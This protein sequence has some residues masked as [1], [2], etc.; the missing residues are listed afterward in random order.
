MAGI[1]VASHAATSLRVESTP[2]EPIGGGIVREYNSAN[3]TFETQCSAES[4]NVTVDRT[5]HRW[6]LGFVAPR[7]LELGVDVYEDATG[8]GRPL[9]MRPE[10]FIQG[11]GAYCSADMYGR[12]VIRE[13]VCSGGVVQSLAVDAEQHCGSPDAPALKTYLRINSTIAPI[14]MQPTASAGRD[15]SVTEGALVTLDGSRSFAPGTIASVSWQQTS[16]PSVTLSDPASLRPSFTAPPVGAGGTTLEFEISVTGSNALVDSNR[17]QV[18]VRDE[19]DPQTLV[20]LVSSPGD[21]IGSGVTRGFNSDTAFFTAT[22]DGNRVSA[23]VAADETWYF[24]F[25]N[26]QGQP[27]V[28]EVYEQATRFPLNSPLKPVLDI[29]GDGRACGRLYGRFIVREIVCSAANVVEKLAIDA[30]Q[31]CHDADAAPLHAY[32]R[33]NSAVPEIVPQPTAAAGLDLIVAEGDL[34]V[35]DGTLSYAPGGIKSVAWSV[36][37]GPAVTLVNATTL[38]PSFAAPAVGPEGATVVL[39]LSVTGVNGLVDSNRVSV[40]IRDVADPQTRLVLVG[41]PGEFIGEGVTRTFTDLYSQFTTTCSATSASVKVNDDID[42]ST[43]L[44]A[45]ASGTLT[46]GTYEGVGNPWDTSVPHL[47]IVRDIYNCGWPNGRFVISEITCGADGK[48]QKL[49]ADAE[50]RCGNATATPLFAFVRVNSNVP[51]PKPIDRGCRLDIDGNSQM[52]RSADGSLLLRGL[53]G[54]LGS[55]IESGSPASGATRRY[56][57][58]L[59][60][61]FNNSCA[62][63]PTWVGPQGCSL[64]LDG[65]GKIQLGTDGVIGTRLIAGLTGDA[66]LAGATAPGATRVTWAQLQPYLAACKLLAVP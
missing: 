63:L 29:A 36:V 20:K 15:Q 16:G 30:E 34:V 49:A 27:L 32:L 46:V 66:V 37:S 55:A 6:M 52:D 45:P 54:M 7:G 48:L 50:L 25:L 18:R 44:S 40:Q 1:A 41:H 62:T 22:C 2:G 3:T 33:I 60:P 9:P 13:L 12:F 11:M 64:D 53:A 61:Y 14:V 43:L 56:S 31:H 19:F 17:V 8:Y 47:D 24:G 39:E 59:E 38:R 5:A 10:Q 35:L 26:A 28:P 65:D 4:L 21:Y 51:I 58:Q 42:W 57:H 23:Q